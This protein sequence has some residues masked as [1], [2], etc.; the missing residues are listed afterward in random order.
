MQSH[1][2]IRLLGKEI[3][4]IMNSFVHDLSTGLWFGSVCLM[5]LVRNQAISQNNPL[6]TGFS[7]GVIDHFWKYSITCFLLMLVTGGLRVFTLQFYGWTGDMA[8]GRNRLLMIKHV[9][10]GIIVCAGLAMQIKLYL[11]Y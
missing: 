7:Q 3:L 5:T 10:L 2:K 8:P 4:V 1:E 6:I 11:R 9:I